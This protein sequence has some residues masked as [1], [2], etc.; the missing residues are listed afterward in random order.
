M[1][2]ARS[3]LLAAE[4]GPGEPGCSLRGYCSPSPGPPR[5]A[6][7][8]FRSGFPGFASSTWVM[9]SDRRRPRAAFPSAQ[10]SCAGGAD[11]CGSETREPY[12]P[13]DPD[14]PYR[15]A[16]RKIHFLHCAS[17]LTVAV[18]G[19]GPAEVRSPKWPRCGTKEKVPRLLFLRCP[20]QLPAYS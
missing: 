3:G 5:L 17:F 4:R 14:T 11:R 6:Q 9:P 8:W 16:G 19:S 12:L 13:R 1:V 18:R 20:S 10:V 2:E 15:E 7:R